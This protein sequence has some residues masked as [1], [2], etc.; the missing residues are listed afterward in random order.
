MVDNKA[1]PD[2]W[3]TWLFA[4]IYIFLSQTIIRLTSF[5]RKKLLSTVNG[6]VLEI[7]CGPGQNFL[8]YNKSNTVI[9]FDPCSTMVSHALANAKK[10]EASITVFRAGVGDEIVD[11]Y[12]PSGG[13]DNILFSYVL[14]TIPKPQ[15]AVKDS[16]KWL[17][18]GGH[19]VVFEHVESQ[20]FFVKIIQHLLQPI[21][22]MIFD[23]CCLH[24]R[25][26]DL[27]DQRSDLK[28]VGEPEEVPF[29]GGVFHTIIRKY[30][31]I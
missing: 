13:V 27:F 17:K 19:V 8:D 30:Q 31:K 2:T 20:N 6:S 24:R 18:K 29:L 3:R 4:Q 21:H 1:K 14:C 23:N 5:H 22:G 12:I 7:G 26:G 9:A 11:R 28:M 25:T 10:A 16:M 15:D